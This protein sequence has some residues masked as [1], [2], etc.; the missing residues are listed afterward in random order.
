MFD[1]TAHSKNKTHNKKTKPN[2]NP[3]FNI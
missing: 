1:K 2:F 3:P